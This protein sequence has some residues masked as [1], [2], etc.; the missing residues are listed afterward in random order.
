MYVNPA[1]LDP[2]SILKIRCNLYEFALKRAEGE[3]RMHDVNMYYDDIEKQIFGDPAQTTVVVGSGGGGGSKPVPQ[4]MVVRGGGPGYTPLH[5]TDG[6]PAG[7]G[8]GGGPAVRID[9][10][11]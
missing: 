6:I 3:Q 8:G 9:I 10:V 2:M 1:Y 11:D 7:H 4:G 5:T